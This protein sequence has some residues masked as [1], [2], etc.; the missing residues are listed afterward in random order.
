VTAQVLDQ[1]G[2]VPRMR[3]SIL[4]PGTSNSAEEPIPPGWQKVRLTEV[5][6]L[7]SG[8][9]PSRGQSSYWGGEIPWI[10]L[11]DTESLDG[12]EIVF[13]KRTVTPEGIANSSARLL[14]KGTVVFSRTATV[15]KSTVMGREM[16]TSQDFANYVCGPKVY[17]HFLVHLFR[18]MA[19]QWKR[20]MA[21]SIHNTVYMPV[22][23]KLEV[24]LPP[25]AEQEAIATALDNIDVLLAKVDALITKKRDLKQAAMQQL[26]TGQTRL[27]GWTGKWEE[28][29]LGELGQFLKGRGIRK[30]EASSGDVA[31]IR[32]G[33]I[34]TQHNDCIRAYSS[35]ISEDVAR[36]AARL[37]RGDLLFAGSGETKE[38][39]GK[40]AA[41]LDDVE[42]Y[43]GGDIIILRPNASDPVFMG[44]Y[45]NTPPINA[46][47]ASRG[48]GDAIVH[49]STAALSSIDVT[50]PEVEEQAAIAAVLSDLDA[51]VAALEARRDKTRA[52]K[53]GM[54]QELLTGRIRLI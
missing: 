30:D 41:F 17:N 44:Y 32:Y 50:I 46:Q 29:R 38:E 36:T 16:A 4:P 37:R 33:E 10:S 52:L 2:K 54:M 8:H 22:F 47:K 19:P 51:E 15:G 7:E 3:A 39:I 20:L 31:C 21:G 18:F 40:C 9:T 27:P 49:I 34:Y 14:P 6:Q 53:Q 42:A 45:L 28:R 35:W 23:E 11:H 26:L 5:A 13:T 43:A 24:T 25:R 48:Q 12:R 1:Q